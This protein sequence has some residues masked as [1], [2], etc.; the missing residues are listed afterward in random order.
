MDRGRLRRSGLLPREFPSVGRVFA[1]LWLRVRQGEQ[2]E[3]C[4]WQQV[5]SLSRSLTCLLWLVVGVCAVNRLISPL[6]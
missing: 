1:V 2:S 4:C 6:A 3:G 5:T